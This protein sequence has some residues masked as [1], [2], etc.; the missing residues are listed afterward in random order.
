MSLFGSDDPTALMEIFSLTTQGRAALTAKDGVV[1][2]EKLSKK[3]QLILR[4]FEPTAGPVGTSL[5]DLAEALF[6]IG[7]T[8]DARNAINDALKIFEDLDRNDNMLDRLEYAILDIC[9][10]QGHYFEIERVF[11]IRIKRLHAMGKEQ[12]VK[13]AIAQ[14]DLAKIYTNQLKYDKALPLALDSLNI[15]ERLNLVE[16]AAISSLYIA[17]IL[18]RTDEYDKAETYGKKAL[19]YSETAHGKNSIN[20][21]IASDELAVTTAFVAQQNNDPTKAAEAIKLSENALKLFQALTEEDSKEF[22]RSSVNNNKLKQMLA[23]LL[24]GESEVKSAKSKEQPLALPTF[25]FISHAF[26]DDKSLKMLINMLPKY[27]KPVVFEAIN[28]PPTEVVSEKLIN[29]LLGAE[30]VIWIDSDVSNS[31]FWTVF[32]RDLAIRKEKHVFRFDPKIKSITPYKAKPRNLWIAHLYHKDD[33]LDVNH[34]MR[35]LV[36]ERSFEAFNDPKKFGERS[37]PPFI[38]ID[39]KEREFHLMSFRSFGAMYVIFISRSFV[40]DNNLLQHTVEQLKHHPLSTIICWLDLPDSFDK[41]VLVNELK[42]IPKT[43]SYTFQNRPS[44]AVFNKH[45]IDDLMV[46]LYWLVYQ[47]NAGGLFR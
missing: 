9:T 36:D 27:V 43:N 35:W 34:I 22:Q 33:I 28:V 42:L 6:M 19:N 12:D 13:R 2:Y 16:D 37:F 5:I 38:E 18:L 26:A 21:A 20:T 23:Q 4:S 41:S 44:A 1:A 47:G 8:S 39:P 29:G 40:Q 17:R 10:K 24:T 30:G 7:K 32:E 25:P 11:L 31:S 14:D 46:R 45:Q 15:F 3:H